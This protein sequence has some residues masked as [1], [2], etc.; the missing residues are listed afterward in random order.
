VTFSMSLSGVAS[1][2]GMAPI[3]SCTCNYLCLLP[4]HVVMFAPSP[5]FLVCARSIISWINLQVAPLWVVCEY[6]TCMEWLSAEGSILLC[7]L[8]FKVSEV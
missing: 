3:I 8:E 1:R 2:I 6:S 5:F 7:E 4:T